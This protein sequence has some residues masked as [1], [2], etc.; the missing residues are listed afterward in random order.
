MNYL[1][2]LAET[3]TLTKQVAI[4]GGATPIQLEAIEDLR[5]SEFNYGSDCRLKD[6]WQP[7]M[8]EHGDVVMMF[9]KLTMTGYEPI[10]SICIDSHGL[11]TTK[12]HDCGDVEVWDPMANGWTDGNKVLHP[13][14][15]IAEKFLKPLKIPSIAYEIQTVENY[16]IIVATV[17]DT[18][19]QIRDII[20]W[21]QV[22]HL[23]KTNYWDGPLAG[24]VRHAD[25]LLFYSLYYEDD[26]SRERIFELTEVRGFDAA[27]THLTRFIW[28]LEL[29]IN[30][31]S[32]KKGKK[33][34]RLPR[35]KLNFSKNTSYGYM[36]TRRSEHV[37][38]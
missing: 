18:G 16:P 30:K 7:Y 11:M 21:D 8:D 35:P 17:A 31:S 14:W 20:M 26:I 2:R 36:S 3:W 1:D 6:M 28:W 22:K 33:W 5:E 12:R 37:T 4:Q 25:Q 34:I 13:L 38:G 24:F 9:E 23:W 32:W 27:E 19:Q 15:C 10:V 29:K